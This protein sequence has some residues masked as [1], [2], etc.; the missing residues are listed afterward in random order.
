MNLSAGFITRPIATALMMVAVVVLGAI[1]YTLL[2]VA[3]LPNIDSPTFQVTAQLPGADPNTMASSVATQL[4]RQF[5]QIPGL[6]QMTSSSGVGFTSITLQ[7]SRSRTVDSAATDVQAAINATQGLLPA[8]LLSQP[9]YRKTN[10]ADAPILLIALSSDVLPIMTVSDYAYSIL[11]Q[12]LSQ[13]PGVGTVAV[14]GLQQPAIRIRVNPALLAAED[15]DFETVRTALSNLTVL[16]PKGQLYGRQQAVALETND[17]LMTPAQFAEAIVAYREGAPILVRNIGTVV[18]APQDVT[19]GGWSGQKPAVILAIQRQPGANVVSTV[20][21]IKQALPRLRASLPPGIDLAIVSDRTVTIQASISDVRFTLLLTIAL[22]VGVIALFLRRLWA[23]AIPAISVPISIVGT[24]AVMSVLGYSLDNLS[25]MALSIAIG[26][27]VDDAIVMVENIVRHIEAGATPL[28]AALDGAGEIGFTILSI[29]FSLVAVFIP[30]FLMSGVVGLLFREFAVTVAVSILVSV[31]VSLTLTPMLCAKLLPAGN[32]RPPNGVSAALE[33]F[34][35]WLN[36]RYDGGLTIALHHRLLTLMTFLGTVALTGYLFWVIPKGFFPQQDTGLIMGIS[37]AAQDV[38]P[39]GMKQRQ[40]AV[41]AIVGR[42][43]AVANVVGYI[44]PGGPTVTE[45]DGRVFIQLKPESERD[46]TADQVIARLSAALRQ[47]QGMTLY[48]QAAQDITI[49]ARL[50]KTQYQFT[51]TDVDSDALARFAPKV[52][53]ALKTLPEL[54]SVASD[55]QAAGRILTAEVDRTAAS[56]LGIDPSIVDATLYDAF[57][58]RHV[59]RIFTAL[60]QYYVI[61]EVDPRYQLGPDALQ[62]IHVRSQNDTSVP[63]SQIARLVPGVAPVAV[64]HQGQFPAVTISFN[65]AP[66]ATIGAAVAA[67]EKAVADLHPPKS[68]ASGF[69]GNAQAFQTSLGSTPPLI[70]AALFAVYIILGMLYESTIHPLTI[71]S[72]LPSAGLGALATLMLTGRP[73][74]MIGIIGII[75]LIGIVKK[76][77]IMLIDVALE[78]QRERGLD[79]EKAAHEACL[80]RFRPILMT[81]MCALLG[82]V[83]L[84]VGTGTGSELRQPLGYT[85]VGGLLVS[86]VLTLFTT[87]VIYIYMDK[88]SALLSRRKTETKQGTTVAQPT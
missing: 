49:G 60:N 80:L 34:F 53:A 42:D 44:G 28:Q 1:S 8:S 2:P 29:S 66:G 65:L 56:R 63:P 40:R 26:F 38:S 51:L 14:G 64:N 85:I 69:Q 83:P 32:A 48:M 57:G 45:N 81:T 36:E 72:T 25:L 27:V 17:Q 20:D 22:V 78:G 74:D 41:L 15:L 58:Q 3:A 12:K 46:V 86:Q 71:L 76:N 24:F 37:E 50:S 30:L 21:D 68:L 10:P 84:M 31:A 82:G 9:S 5:G 33:R 52:L 73:L 59:A 62:R 87:P 19:Q 11:A 61:L 75:L 67:V 79:A 47:V 77:G 55:R 4:E 18:K 43:P 23:T 54:A 70:L 6:T 13:M 39:E 7:F 16:Q 35:T 88:L